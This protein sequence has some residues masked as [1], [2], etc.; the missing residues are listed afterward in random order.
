MR[1]KACGPCWVGGKTSEEV[2]RM[3]E[4]FQHLLSR[5]FTLSLDD[6]KS[7]EGQ[8]TVEYA[9]VLVLVVIMAI[10]VFAVLQ[11]GVSNVM[12]SITSKLSS[13]VPSGL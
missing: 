3:V 4:R 9:V 7:D 11:G 1:G 2:D 10:A 8:T 5:V 12:T 13:L 6:L